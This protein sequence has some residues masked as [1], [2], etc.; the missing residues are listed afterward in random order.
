[1]TTTER[2]T[3][4][5]VFTDRAQADAAVEELRRAGFTDAQIGFVRRSPVEDNALDGSGESSSAA[6]AAT[7]AVGGGVVGG[8]IGAM[9]ALLIPGIGPAVAGGI[10]LTTL[11]GAA[12][13]AVAGGF[14]G[15]LVHM[16]VPE[17]EALY[18]Q[19]QLEKGRTLVTVHAPGRYEEVAAL[20]RQCGAFDT[21][22]GDHIDLSKTTMVGDGV[23]PAVVPLTQ[24]FGMPV[25]GVP[26]YTSPGIAP[27]FVPVAEPD[28]ADAHPDQDPTYES[29]EAYN[30]G[31]SRLDSPTTDEAPS[32]S[33]AGAVPAERENVSPDQ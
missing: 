33:V 30:T 18:Y 7:G 20:L 27:V 28:R 1:M 24:P 8:V 12:I 10:L 32:E 5:G 15:S 3:A 11:G 25:G 23:A 4:V 29:S 6:T 16:G 22:S 17:N 2:S 13:G 14:V 9:T 19:Q 21:T 31:K 26:S